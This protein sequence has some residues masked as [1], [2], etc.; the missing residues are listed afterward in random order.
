MTKAPSKAKPA[1]Q[2]RVAFTTDFN[3]AVFLQLCQI[4]NINP[5]SVLGMAIHNLAIYG[6]QIRVTVQLLPAEGRRKRI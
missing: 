3:S 6:Q 5:K 1:K 4:G 2:R